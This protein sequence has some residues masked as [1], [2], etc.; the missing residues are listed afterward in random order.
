MALSNGASASG[1]LGLGGY[2]V[3]LLY[4]KTPE[5]D[6]GQLASRVKSFCPQTEA[7]AAGGQPPILFA[8]KDHVVMLH[9]G[10]VDAAITAKTVVFPGDLL[11][12]VQALQASLGQTR[13][14]DSAVEAVAPCTA[15][16]GVAD[17]FA[18]DLEPRERLALFQQVLLGIIEAQRPMAIH[19]KP[20][21]KVVDPAA[22]LKASGSAD[23]DAL[24]S[25]AINVRLFKVKD[26]D[27]ELV[28]DTLGLAALLLPDLQVHFRGLEPARVAAHLY[29]C[30]LYVLRH[31]DCLDDGESIEGP[32]PGQ[33]WLCRHSAS[34]VWP[35]RPVIDFHPGHDFAGH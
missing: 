14:W 28:M 1:A 7:A 34:L 21:G 22:L 27:G 15:Q 20:A 11:S 17:L 32:R 23:P 9:D 12:D 31:G 13:D 8:H 16:V 35:P 3:E 18:K 33:T 26:G 5:L 2:G 6:A 30:A 4:P 29:A 24:P 25:A 19:W 10:P